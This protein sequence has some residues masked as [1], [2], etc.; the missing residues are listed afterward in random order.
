MDTLLLDA[1]RA[2]VRA[3]CAL[4]IQ[5]ARDPGPPRRKVDLS[6]VTVAD[7]ASQ[8][9]IAQTLEEACPQIPLVA[10]ED[11]SL[12]R[13]PP[14]RGLLEAVCRLLGE[15]PDRVLARVDRGRGAPG[16]CFWVADPVDGTKGFLGGGQYAVALALVEEGRVV[17]GA[18]GC[19]RLGFGGRKG[20]GGTLLWAVRGRGAWEEPLIEP[21][22][23]PRRVAVSARTGLRS[24]R[25][26]EPRDPA[27]A[28]QALAEGLARCLGLQGPVLRLDSQVKYALVA[29]GEAELYWRFPRPGDPPQW[30]WD[31]AA[32]ALLVEEAGGVATDL[33]GRPLDFGCGRRLS[34]NRGILATNGALHGA[35]LA[36]LARGGGCG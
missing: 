14:G 28:D 18:L 32:G 5:A 12:L 25:R 31:H 27:H 35:V 6:P 20:E 10:E 17:L 1:A 15:P 36:A 9:R 4:C 34:R 16:G 21:G 22:E 26:C 29:R 24:A 8:A 11:A 7:Y 30:V 2:A 23:P 19:P 33:D 3:A 13:V